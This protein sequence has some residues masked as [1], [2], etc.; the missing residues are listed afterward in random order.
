MGLETMYLSTAQAAERLGIS[1]RTLE[2]LRRTGKGPA[3]H[4]FGSVVRYLK[5]DL[6]AWAATRRR[7]ST[8]EEGRGRRRTARWP[9]RRSPRRGM[10]ERNGGRALR[11][12]HR[13]RGVGDSRLGGDRGMCREVE[14]RGDGARRSGP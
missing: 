12:T 7:T 11:G 9:G 2:R 3:Y 14:R 8:R 4:R 1:A 13:G 6:D 5:A 10:G